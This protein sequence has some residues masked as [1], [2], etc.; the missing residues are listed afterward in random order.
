MHLCK[1]SHKKSS[2]RAAHS[3]KLLL[4]LPLLILTAASAAR[5]QVPS[6]DSQS[7]LTLHDPGGIEKAMQVG[8]DSKLKKISKVVIQPIFRAYALASYYRSIFQIEQSS[9]YAR[10]CYEES[11]KNIREKADGAVRCGELLAGNYAIEDRMADWALSMQ[12]MHDKVSPIVQAVT[13]KSD[14]IF[15]HFGVIGNRLKMSDFFGF[16]V[17]KVTGQNGNE[18]VIPR[19]LASG[20]LPGPSAFKTGV[21]PLGIRCFGSLYYVRVNVNGH[22]VSGVLDTG[23]TMTVIAPSEASRLGVHVNPGPYYSLVSSQTTQATSHLGYVESLKIKTKH[24]TIELENAPVQIGGTLPGNIK[25]ILGLNVMNRLGSLLLEKDQIVVHPDTSDVSCST[26]MHIISFV[27]GNYIIFFRHNVDQRPQN[28]VLDTGENQYLFGTS[29]ATAKRSSTQM[30]VTH[31]VR[32]TGNVD[33]SYYPAR[34]YFGSGHD[35]R[36][37]TIA[38]FPNYKQTYPYVMGAD[39]LQDYKVYLDFDHGHACLLPQP[40]LSQP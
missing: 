36:N 22:E 14:L 19:V 38:V 39:I 13:H 28:I 3:A 10:I 16:P 30:M 4:C 1:G 25:I 33:A 23:T 12:A 27:Q 2:G 35:A 15:P 29:S 6:A 34:I 5:A 20:K 18:L 8:D 40:D 26:P 7:Y 21:C 17:E 37:L 31:K 32:V 9:K 24:S 11:L